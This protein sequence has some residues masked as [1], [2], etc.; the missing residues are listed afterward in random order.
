VTAPDLVLEG[1]TV[2]FGG[3]VAVNDVSLL[4]RGSSITGLIGPN[5]AGKTTTFNACT[6]LVSL[7]TGRVMLGE[8]SLNG[9]ATSARA[10]AGLGRTF[11]RMELFDSMTV[12]ENVALGP[13]AVFSGR[14]PWGQLRGSKRER[15]EIFE[16][17]ESAMQRCGIDHLAGHHAGVISTGQRRLVELARAIASPFQF[18]L[19]DE[20]S[21]GLDVPET[22]A[23]GRILLD[24]VAE[25][26]VGVLLVEHDM[27]LVA[28]VCSEMYV[29]DFGRLIYSGTTDDTLSS[30]IVRAAYL[31]KDADG[32]LSGTL[33]NGDAS[34]PPA[35]GISPAHV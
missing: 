12:A 14:T 17:A 3:L 19:L 23:F 20:P 33:S 5:G 11:Q 21:S 29:L 24:Y 1:I 26:A 28:A 32:A 16:R 2:R 4:A 9:L 22:E 18:L 25:T 34:E 15:R 6:G 8:R 35:R 13:T 27:A 30:D 10:K 31:G 7:A